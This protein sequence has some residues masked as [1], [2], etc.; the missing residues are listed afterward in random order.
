MNLCS[1]YVVPLSDYCPRIVLAWH[2][3]WCVRF[4]TSVQIRGQKVI[5]NIGI[6]SFASPPLTS[7]PPLPLR[8]HYLPLSRPDLTLNLPCPFVRLSGTARPPSSNGRTVNASYVQSVKAINQLWVCHKNQRS[9]EFLIWNWL[10][11]GTGQQAIYLREIMPTHRTSE[12]MW[13]GLAMSSSQ[14]M[15]F[16]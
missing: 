10:S 2:G 14:S 12:Y 8:L 7:P 11:F 16:G 6:L 15:L 13:N 5:R 1:K 3:A 9:M 4:G